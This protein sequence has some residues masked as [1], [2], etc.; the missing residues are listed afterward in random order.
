M[1]RN[2]DFTLNI[3]ALFDTS[4]VK[5]KVNDLQGAFKNIKL[6]DNLQRSFDKTIND[7][8]K[9]VNDF[10]SKAGKGIKNKTDANGITKAIDNVIISA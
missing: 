5:N 7:L 4:D 1:A 10:E 6:P 9:S 2:Q 8:V 3:K